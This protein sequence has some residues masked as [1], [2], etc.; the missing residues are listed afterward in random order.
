MPK[1][2]SVPSGYPFTYPF[3]TSALTSPTAHEDISPPSEKSDTTDLFVSIT[4]ARARTAK[5]SCL[6]MSASGFIT[7]F[8]SPVKV[9]I[10]TARAISSLYQASSG[11]SVNPE[12]SAAISAPK[13]RLIMAAICAR[14]R[15]SF[16]AI[17]PLPI[18]VRSPLSTAASIASFDQPSG[19]SENG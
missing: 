18:P 6:V 13:A 8:P 16:G 11:T 5:A 1:G 14:V 4:N 7:P 10:L 19:K 17:V 9:C 12:I 15:L 3:A 2:S